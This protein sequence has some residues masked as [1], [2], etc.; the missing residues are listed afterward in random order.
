MAR[1]WTWLARWRI[2]GKL[3]LGDHVLGHF[4]SRVEAHDSDRFF[5]SK[6]SYTCNLGET[7]LGLGRVEDGHSYEAFAKKEGPVSCQLNRESFQQLPGSRDQTPSLGVTLHTIVHGCLIHFSHDGLTSF[8]RPMCPLSQDLHHT[9]E[10][11]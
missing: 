2:G 9:K 10:A 4:H 3:A 11:Q 8:C 5:P 6:N 1:S 7:C